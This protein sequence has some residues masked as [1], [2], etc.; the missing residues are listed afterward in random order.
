[1]TNSTSFEYKPTLK[2]KLQFSF[3][4]PQPW[5]EEALERV[6]NKFLETLELSDL[7][8][9]EIVP[10]CKTFHTS[11]IDLSHR[12]DVYIKVSISRKIQESKWWQNNLFY[13]WLV[14]HNFL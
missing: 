6:A 12:Y 10:I 13:L 1:M 7:E 8:R 4:S 14:E 2:V 9:Q 3:W 5:P 11:A